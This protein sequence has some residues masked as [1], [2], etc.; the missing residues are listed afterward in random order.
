M[1]KDN[2]P[3]HTII[4]PCSMIGTN[5]NWTKLHHISATHYL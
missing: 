1:A 3:F 4:F 2:I 5:K